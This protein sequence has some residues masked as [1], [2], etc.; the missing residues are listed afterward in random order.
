M[1]ERLARDLR[2]NGVALGFGR[3]RAWYADLDEDE[4]AH[5]LGHDVA[6]YH[7]LRERARKTRLVASR[8]M[9]RE[10]TARVL[11]QEPDEVRLVADHRGRP[12]LAGGSVDVSLSHTEDL[13]IIG[14]ASGGVLGVDVEALDRP[15]LALG[16]AE[17]ACNPSENGRLARVPLPRRN[18]RLVRLWTLKE[19]Y[20]KAT[21]EGL[22]LDFRQLAFRLNGMRASAEFPSQGWTF[23]SFMIENYYCVSIAVGPEAP[24]CEPLT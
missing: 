20:A 16:I 13:L 24:A 1:W 23:T 3:T 19:A 11:A 18:A 14:V 17:A 10:V 7:R 5:L 4:L 9:L 6:R 2:A 12:M 22:R 21:G 15:L 8:R